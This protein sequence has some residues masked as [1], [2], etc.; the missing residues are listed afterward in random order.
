MKVSDKIRA[1]K[2]WQKPE[3]EIISQNI[4]GGGPAPSFYEGV[5]GTIRSQN[6]P[7]NRYLP[8]EGA[9]VNYVS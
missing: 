6:P 7:H 2:A 1:N 8:V 5:G 9:Y 4:C 3:V